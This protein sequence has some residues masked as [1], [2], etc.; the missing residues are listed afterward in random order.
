MKLVTNYFHQFY[1][2][3]GEGV[4]WVLTLEV[5]PYG[6]PNQTV[7]SGVSLKVAKLWQPNWAMKGSL[8]LQ[9]KAKRPSHRDCRCQSWHTLLWCLPEPSPCVWLAWQS[10]SWC[11]EWSGYFW[12]TLQRDPQGS[13]WSLY[14]VQTEAGNDLP[15][16]WCFPGAGPPRLAGLDVG[17]WG[18]TPSQ[19]CPTTLQLLLNYEWRVSGLWE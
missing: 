12:Y 18:H 7:K 14:S 3:L 8:K 15:Q 2:Q 9:K 1:Q 17:P 10:H 16:S 6:V 19:D 11:S 4:N 13:I 5:V